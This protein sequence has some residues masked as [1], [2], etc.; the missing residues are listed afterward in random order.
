MQ[1]F[2]VIFDALNQE[3]KACDDGYEDKIMNNELSAGIFASSFLFLDIKVNFFMYSYKFT[4]WNG[5]FILVFNRS[6]ML[7][8]KK[9]C[10]T[11]KTWNQNTSFH[12]LGCIDPMRDRT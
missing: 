2:I 9:L 7:F 6:L 5:Q 1:G 3:E 10:P 11:C 8:H 12:I 4:R